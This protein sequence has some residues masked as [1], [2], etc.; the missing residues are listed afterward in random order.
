MSQPADQQVC[1][2]TLYMTQYTTCTTSQQMTLLINKQSHFILAAGTSSKAPK[3]LAATA[4]QPLTTKPFSLYFITAPYPL[5]PPPSRQIPS[6]SNAKRTQLLKLQHH[7]TLQLAGSCKL[8]KPSNY[9]QEP[10]KSP[11]RLQTQA[12]HC[13]IMLQCR[14][15]LSKQARCSI[16][17]LP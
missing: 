7:A 2:E 4:P 3:A 14:E 8:D 6:H 12:A 1:Q 13:T 11:K 15:S 16:P 9:R 10:N 5:T 17:A